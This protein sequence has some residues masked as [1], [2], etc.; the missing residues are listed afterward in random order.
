MPRQLP[1]LDTP[2]DRRPVVWSV[3]G[4]SIMAKAQI[5]FRESQ[6]TFRPALRLS[7]KDW[8]DTS[9]A[10]NT[11]AIGHFRMPGVNNGRYESKH[12]VFD[13]HGVECGLLVDG[14]GTLGY[15]FTCVYARG[16]FWVAHQGFY[17]TMHG[18]NSAVSIVDE[19]GEF[20]FSVKKKF[21]KIK[22]FGFG[23][24]WVDQ[25]LAF[26][27]LDGG[28]RLLY[29]T[30]HGVCLFDTQ[31]RD[32]V[33]RIDFNGLIHASSGFSLSPKV[34]LLAVCFSARGEKDP[35]DGEDRY[36][37]FIRLYRLETGTVE[38]EQ[39][40]PGQ[41]QTTWAVDFSEDGRQIR[42]SSKLFTQVYDLIST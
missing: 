23:A 10:Q 8:I 25:I 30:R 16:C 2:D 38:G 31:A 7:D 32:I 13:E 11:N 4:Y 28:D 9:F 12:P 37:N 14:A 18:G 3:Y 17:S 1:Q 20:I 26:K 6:A 21:K 39:K 27:L 29:L 22:S 42:V 40:L 41:T 19:S 34:K 33:S 15:T 35:V 36:S 24:D 5:Y